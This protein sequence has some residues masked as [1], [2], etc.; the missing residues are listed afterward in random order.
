M[1]DQEEETKQAK[2]EA[3]ITKTFDDLYFLLRC[4]DNPKAETTLGHIAELK[5]VWNGE[6]STFADK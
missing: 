1:L 3:K 2:C 4:S 6:E 5:A